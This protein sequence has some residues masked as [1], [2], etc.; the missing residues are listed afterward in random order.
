MET[1]AERREQILDATEALLRRYGLEKT[2]LKD[3]GK[4][5]GITHS[6]LYHYFPDKASLQEA[7]AERWLARVSAPLEEIVGQTRSPAAERIRKWLNTLAALKRQ[8][9]QSDPEMFATYQRLAETLEGL[10]IGTLPGWWI[11]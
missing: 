6:A 11:S 9:V 10:W 4:A 1:N 7:V 5:L 3:V 2:N 8:K